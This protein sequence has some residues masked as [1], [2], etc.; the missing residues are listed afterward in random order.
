MLLTLR[1][2]LGFHAVEDYSDGAHPRG[3]LVRVTPRNAIAN[4]NP[5]ALILFSY[6]LFLQPLDLLQM[7][8]PVFR[9]HLHVV[10]NAVKLAGNELV[11]SFWARSGVF[12]QNRVIRQSR[13]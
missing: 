6:R 1:D 9:H 12:G 13:F 11:P 5:R 2:S 8:R 4:L 3:Y 7:S 10:A